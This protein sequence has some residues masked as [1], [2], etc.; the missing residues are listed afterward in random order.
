MRRFGWH[1]AR[2]DRRRRGYAGASQAVKTAPPLPVRLSP[3]AVAEVRRPLTDCPGGAAYCP[4][5]MTT[6]MRPSVPSAERELELRRFVAS[7]L[8][9]LKPAR[10][11]HAAL[12]HA[13]RA[14]Q[15]FLRADKGCVAIIPFGGRNTDLLFSSPAT[16]I[17]DRE[18]LGRFIR[19]ERPELPQGLLLAPVWRR[20]RPW[21]VLGLGRAGRPFERGMGRELQSIGAAVSEALERIDR[22]R[23]REVRDRIDRKILE[24]I[25]PKDLFYQILH[26]LRSLTRYDHSAALLIHE[27]DD[28]FLTL[29]AEQIAWTKGRSTRIGLRLPLTD[30][31]R[32]LLAAG[33]SLGFDRQGDDWR[34]WQGRPYAALAGLLDWHRSE[35]GG[36]REGTMLCA[37]LAARDGVFG[38]LKVAARNPGTF[39]PFDADLVE[40]FRAH[41]SIA[42]QNSRRAESLEARILLAER[43][44]AMADLA[45]SVSH[46][47]NNALG[48]VLPLLQQMREEVAAGRAEPAVLLGDLEQIQRSLE[49][50]RRIFGG[51]LAFAR[52]AARHHGDARLRT[53]LDNAIAILG[54]SLERQGVRLNVDLPAELPALRAGQGD[55]EQVLLNLLT[56]AREAMPRGG[57]ITLDARQVADGVEVRVQ[58]TGEGIAPADLQRVFEPFYSTKPEGTGLGLP[59]CRS[60][61]W[62]LGGRLAIE[63]LEGRGARVTVLVP[64]AAAEGA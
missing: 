58:D 35:P 43:K 7:L 59:I 12:R 37:P 40:R 6:P 34:E 45:R 49:V 30:D 24:Q 32:R 46:D 56:N 57:E 29:V 48:S 54:D 61:V 1:R 25:R 19:R 16:E 33:E 5:Q 64:V 52:G 60:I 38:V 26:G 18:L 17:W 41:A 23:I 13:L 27:G 4:D 63:S 14:A 44:H 42:L 2:P 8:A 3:G 50:C 47:V 11:V 9:Q 22:D 39:G 62:G 10:E 36:R 55:V 51:M 20:G 31:E 53:A 15:E 28:G 21:A